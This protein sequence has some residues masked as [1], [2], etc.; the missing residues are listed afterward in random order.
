MLV[1]SSDTGDKQVNVWIGFQGRI[2]NKYVTT[3]VLDVSQICLPSHGKLI[4]K[5]KY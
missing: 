2:I 5:A 4:G 3:N 1:S